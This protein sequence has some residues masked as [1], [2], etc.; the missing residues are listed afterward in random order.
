VLRFDVGEIGKTE[1][2]KE[3][4]LRADS[5]VT[6]VGVFKYVNNDG[7]IRRELRHPTDVLRLDSLKTLEM[8]PIT[9]EHPKD[10]LVNQDNA[11]QVSVGTTG[12]NVRPIGNNIVSTLTIT[13]KDAINKIKAGRQELSCGYELNLLE[14]VGTFEGERY[15]FRQTDIRYNHIA[16]VGSARAGSNARISLDSDD[17]VQEIKHTDED[18]ETGPTISD[19][20]FIPND[21]HTHILSDLDSNGNGR[22]SSNEFKPVPEKGFSGGILH[23]HE[24]V[25]NKIMD[26]FG[27]THSFPKI[28]TDSN[29]KP[30]EIK[31]VKI[32]IDGIDYDAA[33]EVKNALTKSTARADE[34]EAKVTKLTEDN[35]K[36]K[37]NFDEATEKVKKLEG[38]NL[39]EEI[40]VGIEKRSALI[41]S[42]RVH[43][44]EETLKK[45]SELTDTQIKEAVVKSKFSEVN[46]DSKQDNY[47]V[48]LQ[49]RFD[50]VIEGGHK[51]EDDKKKLSSISG[52]RQQMNADSKGKKSSNIVAKE[53]ASCSISS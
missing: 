22:T 43:L 8:V 42:A 7:T 47:A 10:G 11:K 48:Y 23:F 49:A 20:D 16:I 4:F 41:E 1:I 36:A 29:N 34:A 12:E 3:G 35:T 2:T 18:D 5:I 37:A 28:N 24:V 14:E 26:S 50:S 25:N 52:Q 9:L 15:D 38:R 53:P 44:D 46:L 40:K 39:D 6:R 21:S 19:F 51:P 33:P 27:H 17:A 31:M 32:T 30:Q 13:H 45:I